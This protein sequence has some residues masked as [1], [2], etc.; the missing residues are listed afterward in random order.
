MKKIFIGTAG[1]SY[2]DWV[3]PFYIKSQS[4]KYDW[5]KYY[6]GYFNSVEVN[7][8]YYAYVN[9]ETV[10][11]WVNK[12]SH[13][14]NFIFEIK[15]HQD[16]THLKKFNKGN[17]NA[18]REN[19]DIL[20]DSERFGSLLLQFPYSF[21][22]NSENISY[23][24]RLSEL[25]AVYKKVVEVRHNSWDNEKAVE[26]FNEYGLTFCSVDQPEVGRSLKFSLTVS[27][28]RAY[29]RL[30]GRNKDEWFRNFNSFK[31]KQTFEEKNARYNYR[32]SPGEL[33]EIKV[34]IEEHFE[35]I[36]EIHVIFNN[37]PGGKAVLNAIELN[38]LLNNNFYE[39]PEREPGLF[40]EL[41]KTTMN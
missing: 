23:L 16:F 3:G 20:K 38:A 13:K 39:M 33:T 37:H 5:L 41:K 35:E 30:H 31:A 2:K 29:L 24:S 15:L 21:H 17:V 14:N 10:K 36:D 27:D 9:N 32:Y 25:F 7:S 34:M 22:M 18:V 4:A 11:N 1:W 8:T 28:R 26:L 19:L 12:V 6:S 40:P